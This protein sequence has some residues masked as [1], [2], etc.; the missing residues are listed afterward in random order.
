MKTTK[1]NT[2][3]AINS[4]GVNRKFSLPPR[5]KVGVQFNELVTSECAG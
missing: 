4:P 3:R 1:S 5:V 2:S